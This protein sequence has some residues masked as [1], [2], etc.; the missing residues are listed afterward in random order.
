[1]VPFENKLHIP[2]V[3]N[4]Y[5]VGCGACKYACPT[6]PY[7]AIYVEGNP[8]H[9]KAEIPPPESLNRKL[10]TKKNF[11]FSKILAP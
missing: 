3:Q 1:M 2:E 9:L 6:K 10:I 8:K 4:E 11:H 7:K 5:C